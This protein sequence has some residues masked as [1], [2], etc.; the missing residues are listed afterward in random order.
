MSDITQVAHILRTYASVRQKSGSRGGG[1]P[2]SGLR[3]L[4]DADLD[5]VAQRILQ[6]SWHNRKA[7]SSMFKMAESVESLLLL[8]LNWS[9]R[10]ALARLLISSLTHA[11]LYRLVREEE[12]DN[13]SP[14]FIVA[15]GR[16]LSVDNGLPHKTRTDH[17]YPVWTSNHD[18]DGNLLV[19]PSHPSPPELEYNPKIPR[20]YEE[21]L[22]MWVEAVHALESVPFRINEEL[23][24]LVIQLDK[25]EKTRIVPK[26]YKP[27]AREKRKLDAR[28]KKQNIRRFE[29][30]WEKDKP[31]W[32]KDKERDEKRRRKAMPKLPRSDG[33]RLSQDKQQILFNFWRDRQLLEEKKKSCED[34]RAKFDKDLNAA[35]K[36]RGNRFFHRLRMCYRGRIY[37]PEFSYQGSDFAR[38]VIEFDESAPLTDDDWEALLIHASNVKGDKDDVALRLERGNYSAADYLR[39]GLDPVDEFDR[40]SRAD[41]PYC[42]LRSCLEVTDFLAVRMQT[43]ENKEQWK[44]RRGKKWRESR[45]LIKK[46]TERWKKNGRGTVVNGVV[47]FSSHLPVELDQSNSA[48]QHIALMMDDRKLRETANMGSVWSDLYTEAAQSNRLNISGLTDEQEKRKIVKLVAVPWSYGANGRTCANDLIKYR[49]ES[50]DK[51]IYLN[52]LTVEQVNSLADDVVTH[53]GKEFKAC[54]RFRKRVEKAVEKIR[55]SGKSEVVQWRTPTLF[56]IVQRKHT[57]RKFKGYVWSGEKD[58]ELMVRQPKRIDWEKNKSSAPANLVHSID[59]AL[60][61]MLLWFFRFAESLAE[62]DGTTVES[63]RPGEKIIYPV[64]TIHDAFACHASNVVD[65]KDKLTSGLAGLYEHYD[66]L[67]AFLAQTEGGRFKP[68][69][70][71][72]DWVKNAKNIF[73]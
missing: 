62:E 64:I 49:Q 43:P 28:A 61:H 56:P 23:L 66:P 10:Y 36:L 47:H 3:L 71:D 13:T 1:K 30:L 70:R 69:D 55:A 20:T 45:Q 2:H 6:R 39:I 52:S 21:G 57:S 51:A 44:K 29:R 73:S 14:Y 12:G 25:K 67:R 48:F 53:L 11:G 19:K 50:P 42:F 35:K 58:V 46:A 7:A 65:L 54:V 38:A 16:S 5:R 33:Y 22:L 9:E 41:K 24:D 40:W 8:Q 59:A 60:I 68:R 32:K 63:L 37:Y 4:K 18:D 17:P 34:R 72:T 31:L 26:T 27:Y 15:T